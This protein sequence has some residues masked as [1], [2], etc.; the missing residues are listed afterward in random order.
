ML[1][2]GFGFFSFVCLLL[3]FFVGFSFVLGGCF[4]IFIQFN[5]TASRGISH[6]FR[7]FMISFSCTLYSNLLVTSELFT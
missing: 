4:C 5:S 2:W 6:P 1:L 3:G 7:R